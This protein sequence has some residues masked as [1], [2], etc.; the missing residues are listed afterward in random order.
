MRREYP[1]ALK[2][3]AER[4]EPVVTKLSAGH[5]HTP[6]M[7]SAVGIYVKM[8]QLQL[9]PQ[10]LT[11]TLHKH[12]IAVAFRPSEVKIAMR[13]HHVSSYAFQSH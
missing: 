2:L 10:L 11:E 9:H 12:H 5:L 3:P 6:S 7:L 4:V 13:R 1:G 8:N